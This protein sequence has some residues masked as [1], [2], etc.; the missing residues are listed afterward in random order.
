M[1]SL[2]LRNALASTG[3]LCQDVQT[4]PVLSGLVF[5]WS[6]VC[7]CLSR[8]FLPH[9]CSMRGEDEK[10][11]MYPGWMKTLWPVKRGGEKGRKQCPGTEQPLLQP[12]SGLKSTHPPLLPSPLTSSLGCRRVGSMSYSLLNPVPQRVE[13]RTQLP[14]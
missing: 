9:F 3:P 8:L 6:S 2:L 1:S 12:V 4:G 11:T 14:A 7:L 5:H 10:L 13:N